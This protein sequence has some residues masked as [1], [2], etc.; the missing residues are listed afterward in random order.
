M[1]KI[2]KGTICLL[3]VTMICFLSQ[4]PMAEEKTA[5]ADAGKAVPEKA[6]GAADQTAATVNGEVITQSELDR[7]IQNV[8]HRMAQI[9]QGAPPPEDLKE[10][11]LE[12]LINR[13]LLYEAS[14]KAG[15]KIEDAEVEQ[16]WENAVSRF[17]DKE[18]FEA[19]MKRENLTQDELKSEIRRGLAI[20][21]Y[22]EDQFV[23]KIE[24]PKEEIKE[25][26]EKNPM[27]FKHPEMVKASHILIKS[28]EKDDEAKKAE[29]RK[30]IEEVE[31]QVKE[32]KD[33]AELARTY[34]D[35]PSKDRGGDLGFFQR[36]QMVKPFDDAA[37]KLKPGE[38]SSI[39]ET[40]FGYHI[41]KVIEKRPEGTYPLE[42]AEP[43][44]KEFL[45]KQKT[46]EEVGEKLDELK[47]EAKIEKFVAMEGKKGENAQ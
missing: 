16:K 46:Q 1:P 36:G 40:P 13:Q 34:S 6:S 2:F 3:A 33:F 28:E 26:Y 18:A 38:V 7:E 37:F 25:Y 22:I 44:I 39:V 27:L 11:A 19:V 8:S 15:V 21:E 29:A 45:S 41:V 24:I 35:C 32:G 12:N 31:K 10:K 4:P 9:M 20:Q 5:G 43:K 17:P 30:K 47:E 23:S 42:E 14:Q